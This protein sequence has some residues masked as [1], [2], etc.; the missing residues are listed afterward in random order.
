MIKPIKKSISRSVKPKTRVA[1]TSDFKQ[2]R[3]KIV[4][5]RERELYG[6]PSYG[7]IL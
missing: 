3:L 6:V 1:P 5:E 4:T 7:Y 2:I